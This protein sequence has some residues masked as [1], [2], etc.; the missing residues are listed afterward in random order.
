MNPQGRSRLALTGVALNCLAAFL[1][2]MALL[3]FGVDFAGYGG[4][5]MLRLDAFIVC[6]LLVS[7][8]ALGVR[9]WLREESARY[10]APVAA[11][12]GYVLFVC[13]GPIHQWEWI[14]LPVAA[15][16]FLWARQQAVD[17]GPDKRALTETNVLLTIACMTALLPSFIQ[18]MAY[19]T[20]ALY[21]SLAVIGIGMAMVLGAMAVRRK[22]PLLSATGIMLLLTIVKA[23]QWAAHREEIMLPLVGVFIGFGIVALGTLFEARM[24]KAL[25]NAVDV[26]K[27]EARMFW[28]SWQ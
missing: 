23:V 12:I 27:A 19:N 4:A 21:H 6:L 11:L 15:F 16:L 9:Y 2:M 25:R 5:D 1:S 28:I 18:A 8:T 24:N 26:A 13:K 20:A 3:F 14:T 10:I 17:G 7:A 22:I